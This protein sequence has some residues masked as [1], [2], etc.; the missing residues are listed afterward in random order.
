LVIGDAAGFTAVQN[1]NG[2][3]EEKLLTYANEI[4]DLER[5]QELKEAVF[6]LGNRLKAVQGDFQVINEKL[7]IYDDTKRRYAALVAEGER[8]QQE[9]EI[10][11]QRSAA[12]VQGFR[13]RDAAFRIFRN[14]KL[15]RYKAL[16]DLS[17]RYAY[18]A[19]NAYDYDTGL[20]NTPKGR[21]FV[22][23]IVNSRALGVVQ[24]GDPQ[25]AGSNLGDPGLSSVLAEMRADW[26]VVKGRLGFNNPTAYGTTFSLRTEKHRILP[27]AEGRNAWKD[28]L[29][30]SRTANLLEDPDVRRFCMQIDPGNGL[31][32]PGLVVE[33]ETT[34]A[35]GYNFFGQTQQ[36]WDHYFD[37]S[38]F[39]TKI[40]AAGIAFEGY[41]G[42]D[43]PVAN[44]G[45][46]GWAG[47][48]SAGDPNLA[49]LDPHA[50]GATPG[51]YLVPV[52]LD[53]MRSPALGDAGN[54]RT[55]SVEDV[56]IPLPFNVGGSEFSSKALYQSGDSLSEPL[57]G[58][59]KH[60]SFRPVSTT[61]A[62]SSAIYGNNGSL[63]RSQFTNTRL[64]GRSVWNSKWKLVIPGKK[65]LHDPDEGLRRFIDSV[66][67]IKLHLV[68]YSHAGN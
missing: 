20:L 41:V 19:A 10:F 26:E 25:F 59:R 65:L 2:D 56:T 12:I 53:S 4:S 16:F 66:T 11:R 44:T 49:F 42:M 18:L 48:Q 32:V 28:V 1:S 34:I 36:A 7:R 15:E 52:G 45:A 67:D 6:E 17:A 9:R 8:L 31:P 27:T 37:S 5:Q 60:A 22:A 23:R 64:I 46:V 40:F 58:I 57:F 30:R 55:W 63:Q 54:I 50:L 3:L 38:S 39:A 61:A 68:T 33:F 35:D 21:E 13:T 24:D 62:F 43:N 47:G 51:V 14:E 29:I